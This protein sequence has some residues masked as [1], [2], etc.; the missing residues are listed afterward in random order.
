MRKGAEGEERIRRAYEWISSYGGRGAA[1][2]TIG[3]HVPYTQ[4]VYV[5]TYVLEVRWGKKAAQRG[6]ERPR[7]FH[8]RPGLIK[9]CACMRYNRPIVTSPCYDRASIQP[10][11]SVRSRTF[12]LVA[13][14][15][16]SQEVIR[17]FLAAS[18]VVLSGGSRVRCSRDYP[19]KLLSLKI[20][21]LRVIEGDRISFQRCD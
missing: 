3:F 10:S 6:R 11:A 16:I 2:I 17:G 8:F 14:R 21:T 19:V 7:C 18:T 13:T 4:T 15:S 20:V 9:R 12:T 1:E 5:R